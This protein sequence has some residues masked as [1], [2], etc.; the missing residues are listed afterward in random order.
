MSLFFQDLRHA[1]RRLRSSPG[2]VTVAVLTLALG[3][4]VNTAMFSVIRGVLLRPL[5]YRDPGRLVMIWEHYL[6][7]QQDHNTVAPANY[8]RWKERARSFTDLAMYTWSSMVFTGGE[9][10]ERVPGRLVSANLLPVLGLAP[11][12][13]RGFSAAEGVDGAPKVIVLSHGL[14]QRRFGG[15]SSIVGREVSIAGGTVT[16][17]GVMP[18]GFRPLGNEQYWENFRIGPDTREP[19]GRYAMVIG[20]LAPGV[21]PAMAQAEMT[22][23]AA[24]VQQEIPD[25]DTGWTATVVTLKDEVVGHARQLLLVLLGAVGLVLLIACANVANLTLTRAAGRARDTAVRI[26]LGA[27]RR[28]LAR[29]WL[30]ESLLLAVLGGVVGVVLAEWAVELLKQL[31]AGVI[32]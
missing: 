15:D 25:F 30:V 11:A 20:R 29:E 7:R 24:A 19:M 4:G 5:P 9:V 2:F 6:P 3:F 8:L 13:G 31:P 10:S 1:L 12:L 27:T 21:T 28:R 17:I 16:V 26:A 22:G 32:P 23:V 14:W 18:A